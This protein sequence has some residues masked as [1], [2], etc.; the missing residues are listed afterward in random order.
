MSNFQCSLCQTPNSKK[1][2]TIQKMLY[3]FNISNY[4]IILCLKCYFQLA[5]YSEKG[6]R[7]N[8][9]LVVKKEN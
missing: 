4:F 3:L 8:E 7:K 1:K 9:L 6:K 5:K 2:S